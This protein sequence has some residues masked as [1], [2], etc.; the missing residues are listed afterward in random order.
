[1][2]R[3]EDKLE[4]LDNLCPEGR[5]NVLTC[6]LPKSCGQC[7]QYTCKSQKMAAGKSLKC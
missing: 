1:M 3:N 4:I 5:I 7:A 6:L 2:N